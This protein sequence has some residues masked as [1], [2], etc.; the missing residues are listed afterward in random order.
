MANHVK[1][2]VGDIFK[3][4]NL[5]YAASYISFLL[6]A[7]R[8]CVLMVPTYQLYWRSSILNKSDRVR[9]KRI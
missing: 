3:G 2:L 1:Y 4:G 8:Q 5:T 9:L 7:M 6:N